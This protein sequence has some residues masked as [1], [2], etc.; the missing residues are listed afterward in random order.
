MTQISTVRPPDVSMSR[1]CRDQSV[2][3]SDTTPNGTVTKAMLT[4]G[5]TGCIRECRMNSSALS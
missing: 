4:R 5:G 1:A 2:R 3:S